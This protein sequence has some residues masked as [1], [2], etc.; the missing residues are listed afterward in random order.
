[1]G[2]CLAGLTLALQL[3]QVRPEKSVLV[4]EKRLGL[5]PPAAFKVGASTV[6]VS[7]HYFGE[8]LGMSDHMQDKHVYGNTYITDAVAGTS[9]T[10]TSSRAPRSTTPP[11]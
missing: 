4:A 10:R 1:M 2:G 7:A 6:D 9:A 5:A 8:V 3:N 11:T